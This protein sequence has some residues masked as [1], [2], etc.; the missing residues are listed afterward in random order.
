MSDLITQDSVKEYF[1][2]ELRRGRRL[3]P[4]PDTLGGLGSYLK[5]S[6]ATKLMSDP[7]VER[8][9]DVGC[10]HGSVEA[11]FQVQ[12]PEQVSTTTIEGIDISADAVEHAK[13]LNLANCNFQSYDGDTL[14]FPDDSFD[15]VVMI[16]VIEHV[17]DKERLFREINRVLKPGGKLL[18]TTPNPECW[19]LRFEAW[20]F[21]VARRILGRPP[22]EKDEY[23]SHAGL[24][25]VFDA[26]G[27]VPAPNRSIY[28]QPRLFFHIRGW[29][30][31]PPLPPRLLY[32]YH[33]FCLTRMNR[34]P[35]FI[36]RHFKWSL[37]GEAQKS[38]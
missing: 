10:N 22:L 32:H 25:S 33:K 13:G 26:T 12:F 37:I 6:E 7:G 38:A 24:L 16:E 27:F 8:V 11:L 35:R 28:S 31:L 17:V 14:P 19:P 15:A 29:S 21:S 34:L 4:D 30:F 1:D 9:L 18:V 2:G 36:E 3:L 23:L 5:Y 20:W